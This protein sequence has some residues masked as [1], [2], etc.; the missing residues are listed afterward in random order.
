MFAANTNAKEVFLENVTWK[1]KILSSPSI[2]TTLTSLYI[3][4]NAFFPIAELPAGMTF[5]TLNLTVFD[6]G[7]KQHF[8]PMVFYISTRISYGNR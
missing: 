6:N 4:E 1:A 7:L 8:K 3:P 5:K 2:P